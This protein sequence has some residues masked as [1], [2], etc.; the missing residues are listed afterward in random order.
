VTGVIVGDSQVT[1]S[2]TTLASN[3][4]PITGYAVQTSTDGGTTWTTTSVG[5]VNSTVVG[6]LINGG[7][8]VFRVA[9]TTNGK[10]GN[11]SSPTSP[12]TPLGL[13]GVPTG[14]SATAGD[15]S[16]RLSWSAPAANG[17]STVNDYVVQYREI[18]SGTWLTLAHPASTATSAEVSGLTNGATYVFR[19]AAVTSFGQGGFTAQSAAVS[20]LRLAGAPTRLTGRAADGTVSLVWTAPRMTGGQRITD[21]VIDYSSD[22]GLNWTRA[23]DAVSAATRS[24]V[25]V[26]NGV[27]YVFRVAAVTAGGVGAF[28]LN[29]GPLTPFSR[30]AK[31]AAPTALVG[32]GS[33]GTIALSWVGSPTNAG[34][35]VS[36]YVIQ[37][38]LSTSSRWVTVRDGVSSST[39]A[40][41]SRLV[42]GRGYVLR[43]AAKNLAGQGAFSAETSEVIA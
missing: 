8:Y 9:A 35:R 38:R 24:T 19:V 13:P 25:A 1:L 12:V 14:L 41:V 30:A 27:I 4:S 40:I 29:S 3:G 37:Y 32:I 23:A 5:V 42:A 31:P 34:G 21:Y 36:D 18:S 2:W 33:G 7:S 20:P 11:Y 26:P 39:S 10:A 28:S 43:V 22:G 15:G 16:A 17:G 6:S